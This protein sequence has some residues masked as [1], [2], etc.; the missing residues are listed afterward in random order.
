ML[1]MTAAPGHMDAVMLSTGSSTSATR[2]EGGDGTAGDVTVTCTAVSF[3][4]RRIV[5]TTASGCSSG[6]SRQLT[7]AAAVCGSAL[8]AWPP[9][10]RVATQ[11]VRSTALYQA[12]PAASR[13]MAAVSP[14]SPT[15]RIRAAMVSG[16]AAAPRAK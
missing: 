1:G 12:E 11:V 7:L 4:T 2:G 3:T 10:R 9:S 6:S 14:L 5:S 15:I 8:L 13:R 16:S